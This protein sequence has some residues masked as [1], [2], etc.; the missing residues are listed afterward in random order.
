MYVCMKKNKKAGRKN[1]G[2]ILRSF[3]IDM[4]TASDF[5]IT[6]AIEGKYQGDVL[7]ELMRYYINNHAKDWKRSK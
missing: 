4:E 5:K 3:N 6:C 2:T 7:T 1:E